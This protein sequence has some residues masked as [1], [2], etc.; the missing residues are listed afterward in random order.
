MNWIG[1]PVVQAAS[2]IP[3][4]T[5]RVSQLLPGSYDGDKAEL[6]R[7]DLWIC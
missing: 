3:V 1:S 4:S 6:L 7:E 2:E 5:S